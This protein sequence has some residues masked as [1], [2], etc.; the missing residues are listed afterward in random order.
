LIS[1]ASVQSSAPWYLDRIDQRF[2][3]L[4]GLYHYT[5]TAT[6]IIAVVIDTG[7]NAEHTQFGGRAENLFN[8][9]GDDIDT[10]CNGHGTHVGG[11]IGGST[12]GVA[13]NIKI[14]AIK[15]LDCEGE[16]TTFGIISALNYVIAN[17]N[18]INGGD[19]TKKIII[20]MSLG[21]PT[22]TSLDNSVN[23]VIQNNIPVIIAAGN[24]DVSACSSSP[25]R[26]ADALTIGA[27][28]INDVRPSWSNY[29]SCVDMTAPG[30]DIISAW[31]GSTTATNVIS[32]TSM[33]SPIACGVA[34]LT[35]QQDTTQLGTTVVETVLAW[36]TP[37][38][39]TQTTGAGG[40]KNLVYSLIDIHT[41]PP[42]P[43]SPS[44]PISPPSSS[45]GEKRYQS[46]LNIYLVVTTLIICIIYK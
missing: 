13:K 39:I 17:V 14:S 2:G 20:N 9:A 12:Y 1:T 8:T 28:D 31:I 29:G 23:Q 46:N 33:A 19:S 26:V 34:A 45:G 41:N 21:G 37:N 42:S 18:S 5:N 15:A 40:G 25:A 4:D 32:G 10:D 27:S 3:S 6:D 36:V 38:V 24:E 11:L 22:S 43:P 35:W 44:P 16:G 7:I 30:K